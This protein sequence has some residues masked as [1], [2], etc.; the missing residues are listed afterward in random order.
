MIKAEIVACGVVFAAL[1]LAIPSAHA[2]FPALPPLPPAPSSLPS[3]D[4]PA[5]VK[6]MTRRYGLSDDQ[7]KSVSGIMKEQTEKA[8]GVV[9]D[10]SLTPEEHIHRLL[11]IREEEITR[12]SEALTPE[13]RKKYQ[14]DVHPARSYRPF[15]DGETAPPSPANQ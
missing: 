1:A 15:T 14:A 4:I 9:K 11:S 6:N 3:R 10:D 5:E 12:V 8:D 7:A 13:Q 2:Q